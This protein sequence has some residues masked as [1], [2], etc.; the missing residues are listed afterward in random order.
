[1][2]SSQISKSE[3]SL[4]AKSAKSDETPER[5]VVEQR[6]LTLLKNYDIVRFKGTPMIKTADPYPHY[7]K[8]TGDK[9]NEVGYADLGGLGRSSMHDVQAWVYSRAP[10]LESDTL[11]GMGC[12]A[13]EMG[14]DSFLQVLNEG[15]PS[16]WDA[17][18]IEWRLDYSVTECFW[19]SPYAPIHAAH[20]EKL[21]FI[22]QLA[23]GDEGLYDDIMQSMAPIIMDKKPD[24]VIWWVGTGAN[25]KSTL[26]DALY[27]LFPNQFASLN[28][29]RLT[30]GRDL[31][32]LN[33][34]L[35]NVVKESSEGRVDDTD[36]YKTLGTHENLRV[37]KFH[38]QDDIE[39]NGN[40]HSIFSANSIPSFN[41]KGHSAQRRTFI[42][43]FNQRFESDPDFERKTFTPEFFGALV[44]EMTR[45]AI[46]LKKQGYRYKWSGATL[47]AKLDYDEE[48]SNGE[49]YA[50]SLIADGCVAFY[51]YG[52]IENDYH[53]WCRDNG[54]VPL[55]VTNLRKA[56]KALGFE[57]T[58]R[59]EADGK[60]GHVYRLAHIDGNASLEQLSI[61]RPG[62]YTI[63]GFTPEPPE[64]PEKPE[65]PRQT[66]ILDGKW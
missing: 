65:P 3:S 35:A 49:A 41:D 14:N 30:D 44:A 28:V 53:N 8:L 47:D 62:L 43:P 5:S 42:I 50:A 19:R 29:K 63:A 54:Y 58:S 52:P 31:P 64:P 10:L 46:R 38:S 66:T 34:R 4:P 27:K 7:T 37:H 26:M 40:I 18:D 20:N 22:L 11:I 57:R 60:M 51:S 23:G 6:G 56:L 1:M 45:Y 59:R 13:S 33:G 16:V 17:R 61:I 32:S 15:T 48:S 24:G 39:I 55:G 12:L 2:S 36:V 9:F 25:G 21:D